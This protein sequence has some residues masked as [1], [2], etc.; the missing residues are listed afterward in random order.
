M[1]EIDIDHLRGWI[2]REQTASEL[3]TDGLVERFRATLELSAE[4]TAPRLIHLCLAPPAVPNGETGPDGHPARGGFLPPVP[5][6]SRMWAG[7]AFDFHDDPRVGERVVRHSRIREVTLK[8]GRTGPLCFVTVDHRISTGDRLLVEERQDIVY[9]GATHGAPPRRQDRPKGAHH[10]HV[11]ASPLVL[12]RYSALTFNGHRIHYDQPYAT[13]VE[14]YPGLV[15]HG[16]LQATWLYHFA[17][18]ILGAPPARFA[19]RGV[20]PLF[21]CDTVSLNAETD[22]TGLRLWTA[23][24]DGSV[25]MEAEATAR[26]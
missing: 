5:L 10:R 26:H 16:P 2:G 8:Q 25:G 23:A 11:A 3:L 20:G 18:G 6:P 7:G 9:R 24:G 15:V 17:A 12:F 19:F 4:E 21:D 14:G 13:G 22:T 1:T